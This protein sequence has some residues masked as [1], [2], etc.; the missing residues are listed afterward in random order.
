M[1]QFFDF[2]DWPKSF[3]E[4][5]QGIDAINMLPGYYKTNNWITKGETTA[6]LG[7]GF[8]SILK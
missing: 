7:N 4:N 6:A 5:N 2:K 8:D 1:L 3:K